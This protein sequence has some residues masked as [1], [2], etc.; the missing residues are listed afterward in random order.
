MNR[1]TK[2][3]LFGSVALAAAALMSTGAIANTELDFT[4]S[5]NDPQFISQFPPPPPT[6]PF[7][8]RYYSGSGTIDF[9]SS[10]G[11]GTYGLADIAS[12][13]FTLE[14]GRQPTNPLGSPYQTADYTYTLADLTSFSLTML[15]GVPQDASFVIGPE[16]SYQHNSPGF[17]P[18][19][20]SIEYVS[21]VL[22]GLQFFAWPP[23]GT[24]T[25]NAEGNSI[26]G[27]FT[28]L[29]AVPEPATWA[30]M[31]AGFGIAGARMRSRRATPR[32]A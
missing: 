25:L 12:F 2:T 4:V 8:N 11:D 27:T 7:V 5:A 29:A 28:G 22:D 17:N 1:T 20:Q 23:G 21:G 6:P 3:A 9:T 30:L 15:G 24:K 10:L 26:D 31:I 19:P 13:T 16:P 14:F 18:A 32:I